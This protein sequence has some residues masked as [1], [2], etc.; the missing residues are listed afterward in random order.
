MSDKNCGKIDLRDLGLGMYGFSKAVGACYAEA[1]GVCLEKQGHTCGVI[2][3]V[4]GDVAKR[5]EVRWPSITDQ[6]RRGH[7]DLQDATEDGACGIAIL[8]AR[9][10]LGLTVVRK[11][12]KG[13]DKGF[14]YWLGE[15]G[16]PDEEVDKLEEVF[17]EEAGVA[18]HPFQNMT[19]LE[20]SGIRD[21]TDSQFRSRV[22]G[23]MQQVNTSLE[24]LSS[25]VVVVEFG[26]PKSRVVYSDK[27]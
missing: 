5:Y 14:D 2:M 27:K 13:R 19:K 25:V 8:L 3:M 9:N 4:D 26:D 21:R 6:I 1:A 18:D 17:L 12:W 7:Y 15:E 24:G 20:V 10:C 16:S 23:K 22:H 11:S